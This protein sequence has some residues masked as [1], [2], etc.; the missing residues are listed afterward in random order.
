MYRD[1]T[2]KQGKDTIEM[3]TTLKA[4]LFILIVAV[5]LTAGECRSVELEFIPQGGMSQPIGEQGDWWSAGYEVGLTAMTPTAGPFLWG[6]RISF[7]RW[8]PNAEEMVQVGPYDFRIEK[9]VGWQTITELSGIV[10]YA[11]SALDW[12]RLSWSL[13]GGAGLFHIRRSEVIVKGFASYYDDVFGQTA[14]NRDI[15]REAK[16]EIAPGI[17]F[18]VSLEVMERIKPSVRFQHIFSEDGCSSVVL[19]LGLM[20]R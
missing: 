2:Q 8:T 7:H 12:R 13:E 19:G 18:G 10:C 9:N 17:S 16:T 4:F 5:T 3:R 11:P 14:L 20:A 15:Y 1:T 6:G